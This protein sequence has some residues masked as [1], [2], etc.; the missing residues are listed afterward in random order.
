VLDVLARYE[1]P[2][3][4]VDAQGRVSRG[5]YPEIEN[6]FQSGF[7]RT[8][9]VESEF[10]KVIEASAGSGAKLVISY[11]SPSGL[12]L[13][14]YAKQS[15]KTNPVSRLEDLCREHYARVETRRMPVL[16]SGQGDK[17]QSVDE[18]LVICKDPRSSYSGRR[19]R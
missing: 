13:K 16:H 11:A 17:N 7:C 15:P 8:T 2:R 9:E 5:R 19:A 1:Y 12:L 14:Q 4:Q 18:L 3:L 10:R 6:R